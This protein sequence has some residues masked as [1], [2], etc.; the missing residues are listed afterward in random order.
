MRKWEELPKYMQNE[1]VRYCYDILV[2]KQKSLKMKRLF[3]VIVSFVLIIALLP[4]LLIISIMV[5]TDSKGPVF[6]KQIRITAYGR[7]FKIFKFRTMVD[8]AD[9]LGAQVTTK[10]DARITKVGMMLR[11]VRLDE[12]PQ[13][14]NVFLGD[15]TFVGTRPE[16]PKYVRYYTDEMKATLL[17]PAGIT[18]RTSIE[19][20][21]EEKL[22]ENAEDA[23]EV[24]IHQVMPAKM[25][26]NLQEIEKFS[27]FRDICT[28]VQTVIAVL[29]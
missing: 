25:K 18:S 1:S 4:V 27:F 13:L 10:G 2:D 17:L 12:L 21:D 11:K 3:D 6:Y 24:Y 26:Y 22:L 20:K 8:H 15:M 16:V 28:M 14:F 29:R 23:D 19:Y 5:K 7:K 9:Q